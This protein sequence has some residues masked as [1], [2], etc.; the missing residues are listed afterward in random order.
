MIKALKYSLKISYLISLNMLI[1]Y[2]SKLPIIG[3]FIETSK[4][5]Q[6]R[7]I[8]GLYS[9]CG[10]LNMLFSMVMSK[11]LYLLFLLGWTY[12]ISHSFDGFIV[13]YL[14]L[15]ICGAIG[16]SKLFNLQTSTKYSISLLKM[17]AQD[18]LRARYYVG[19]FFYLLVYILFFIIYAFLRKE[20]LL[21]ALL[22]AVSTFSI[23][24]V[25]D[26]LQILYDKKYHHILNTNKAKILLG[27]L[28][29]FL[30]ATGLMYLKIQIPYVIL[31][32][33]LSGFF[34]ISMYA[35]YQLHIYNEYEHIYKELIK[36]EVTIDV[37]KE[38][39]KIKEKDIEVGQTYVKNKKG[40]RLLN[41]L[42]FQRYRSRLLKPAFIYAGIII[43]AGMLV[44]L[45]KK[46][47]PANKYIHGF[48][49]LLVY[50]MCPGS[51]T[52]SMMFYAC[53]RALLR[54]NF[55]RHPHV[56]FRFFLTRLK[57]IFTIT[58]IPGITFLFTCF[59]L[60][61]HLS[62]GYNT[63]ER[64]IFL[65]VSVLLMIF[66]SVHYLG[67]YYLFQPFNEDSEIKKPAYHVINSVV[68][69]IAL[70]AGNTVL[71]AKISIVSFAVFL[72][73]FTCIYSALIIYLVAR[74]GSKRFKL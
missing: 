54:Y 12:V 62:F 50:G 25:M 4:L 33:V 55:Y 26:Y 2:L 74:Y 17:R 58:L 21:M 63:L 45:F 20:S 71:S 11:I 65:L 13:L 49:F 60:L 22:L 18:Y 5:H 27:L 64:G 72:V 57:T 40:Y 46:Y 6:N 48:L 59:I 56:V 32:L 67:L 15:S 10:L 73:I 69:L 9:F 47:I 51:K 37:T 53:D 28:F 30:A 35:L 44:I 43:V 23:K 38:M 3:R 1:F 39:Y 70:N 24:I 31:W 66:Y 7:L 41:A 8:H 68:Y 42:F 19:L 14:L 29:I 16:N 36:N 61:S 34:I 52:V